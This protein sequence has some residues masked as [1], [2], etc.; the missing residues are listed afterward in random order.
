MRSG[1]PVGSIAIMK[2]FTKTIIHL[3]EIYTDYRYNY[4]INRNIYTDTTRQTETYAYIIYMYI[5]LIIK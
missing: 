5:Y 1:P 3:T 2:K 4:T